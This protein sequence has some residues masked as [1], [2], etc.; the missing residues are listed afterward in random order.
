MQRTCSE[1]GVKLDDY[2]YIF[3]PDR[4][5]EIV[6]EIRAEFPNLDFTITAVEGHKIKII[7]RDIFLTEPQK[8]K[9]NNY[10]ASKGYIQ[11]VVAEVEG[12]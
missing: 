9:M 2:V 8:V 4:A 3:R 7:L 6:E 5:Q 12:P 11:D 1:C 10:F